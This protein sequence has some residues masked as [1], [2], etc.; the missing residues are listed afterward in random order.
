M[1]KLENNNNKIRQIKG[2]P[3]KKL[4]RMIRENLKTKA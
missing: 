4:F 3:P 1:K 2:A